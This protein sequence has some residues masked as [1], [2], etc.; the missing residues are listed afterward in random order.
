MRQVELGG[1]TETKYLLE[2]TL[3]II[4]NLF[5]NRC[6]VSNLRNFDFHRKISVVHERNQG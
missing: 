1:G 4:K 5:A 2:E 6:L 3:P